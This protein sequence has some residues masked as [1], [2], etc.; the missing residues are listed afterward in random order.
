MQI[1]D[2]PNCRRFW[3]LVLGVVLVSA[4]SQV[5][6]ADPTTQA[7]RSAEA[8][9]VRPVAG[10][11]LRVAL[12]SDV[13]SVK[14]GD[15]VEK[16]LAFE[17]AGFEATRVTAEQI[18]KGV[19]HDFDVFV[20]GGGSGSKIAEALQP[21]GRE[22]IKAFVRDGGGYLG[23]CAGAYL[24][25]SDY[26]WSLHILNAKVIDRAHWNRGGGEVTLALS[27]AGQQLLGVSGSQF[28]CTYNQGP[29]L[30][31]DDKEGLPAF[32]SLA[33]FASE[34]AKKGAPT[35]VM[36]GTIAIAT[37]DYGQGRVAVI[38]PHPEKGAEYHEVIRRV[39]AWA[40]KAP[41]EAPLVAPTPTTRPTGG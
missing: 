1:K 39:I 37:A 40:G 21:E 12:Y 35:G 4:V 6:A 5:A 26:K 36:V 14:G 29:L 20:A 27:E 17:P 13:G 7:S 38:S 41:K 19:L 8:A 30:A 11:K 32:T 9:E 22:Q 28:V 3:V 2:S 33:T 25:T 15:N 24:A 16:C 23:I 18:R 10:R 31:P 34:I